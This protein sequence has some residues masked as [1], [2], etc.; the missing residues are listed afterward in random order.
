MPEVQVTEKLKHHLLSNPASL[1]AHP[2][3]DMSNPK[4]PVEIPGVV[5]L[6]YRK[7][8]SPTRSR[9]VEVATFE[10]ILERIGE[11]MDGKS[12]ILAAEYNGKGAWQ[13]KVTRAPR[14]PNRPDGIDL[15]QDCD[16]YRISMKPE[17]RDGE[18]PIPPHTNCMAWS[19]VV[20]WNDLT[21]FAEEVVSTWKRAADPAGNAAGNE[22]MSMKMEK[23]VGGDGP[24][25]LRDVET[26]DVYSR[27][28]PGN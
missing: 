28:E 4:A 5:E 12:S 7:K 24:M 26:G 15:D 16:F 21:G 8:G 2:A 27:I 22:Y 25:L 9:R 23:M 11:G 18:P 3:R 17:L 14:P 1:I 20:P 10:R 19:I 13:F 6:R